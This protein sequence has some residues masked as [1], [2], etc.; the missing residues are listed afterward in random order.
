MPGE[1]QT[2]VFVSVEG[3]ETADL[4]VEISD[5]DGP[6]IDKAIVLHVLALDA[7]TSK[8]VKMTLVIPASSGANLLENLLTEPQWDAVCDA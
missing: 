1:P 5:R 2:F 3:R 7:S 4:E 6:L 8:K